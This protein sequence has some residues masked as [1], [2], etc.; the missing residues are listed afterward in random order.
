M[1]GIRRM[2]N[3][4]YPFKADDLTLEEWEDLA[5]LEETLKALEKAKTPYCPFMV[6]HG[7]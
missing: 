6:H 4:G 7:E 5:A 2:R 1:I 3:A